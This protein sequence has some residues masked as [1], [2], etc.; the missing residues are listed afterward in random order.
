MQSCSKRLQRPPSR[1]QHLRPGIFA[2][3]QRDHCSIRIVS[4]NEDLLRHHIIATSTLK[5]P[6][7]SAIKAYLYKNVFK[8]AG[9]CHAAVCGSDGQ[10][11]TQANAQADCPIEQTQTAQYMCACQAF[12]HVDHHH[13][14]RSIVPAAPALPIHLPGSNMVVD[15]AQAT[16]IRGDVRVG[17][18]LA[19]YFLRPRFRQLQQPPSC[20]RWVLPES[21]T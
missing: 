7:V 2:P 3:H 4:Y 11:A 17:N 21:V 14:H 15:N 16:D 1:S 19:L 20:H 5:S 12:A 6:G 8:C 9:T 13:H 18:E 10:K